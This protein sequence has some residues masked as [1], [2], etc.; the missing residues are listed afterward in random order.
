M[1]D[2]SKNVVIFSFVIYLVVLTNEQPNNTSSN[3]SKS[4]EICDKCDCTI[5]PN[6]FLLN[7]ANRDLHNIFT[8]WPEHQNRTIR[9]TFSNNVISTLEKFPN[10]NTSVMVSLD[11]CSI[12]YLSAGLFENMKNIKYIDLSYNL[13][14]IEEL[15]S[16]KFK[17]PYVKDEFEP[18]EVSHLN[19]AYNLIH[20]LP[21]SLFEHMPRL[22]TLNLEGN[23]IKILD[24][25]TK[26]ALVSIG[27]LKH[28][29]LANNGLQ[30]L[31]GD[32]LKSMTKLLK[33]NLSKNRM[34]FVPNELA[35]LNALEVLILDSNPIFELTDGLFNGLHNL[36]ELSLN[37]LSNVYE[38]HSNTF[39][40]LK[41][42]VKLHLS[43]NP[44]L[45]VFEPDAFGMEDNMSLREVYLNNNNLI[46]IPSVLLDWPSLHIFEFNNNPLMCSCNLYNITKML[47]RQI[48]RLKAGPFCIGEEELSYQ[49][50][51]L[52]DRVCKENYLPGLS[53][54]T[55]TRAKFSMI[56][57]TLVTISL[58]ALVGVFIV[59]VLIFMK[60]RKYGLLRNSQLSFSTTVLYNPLHGQP[61]L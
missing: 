25:Q 23:G 47:R 33:I 60:Q 59:I 6:L 12:K 37:N 27:S 43:N 53:F 20:S 35:N 38:V 57:I 26:A 44:D 13:I 31:P 24:E 46:D 48:T 42:L 21:K 11:H 40:P 39:R 14:T 50:F 30:Q 36:V 16:E 15:S 28:L 3:F 49:V 19:L 8:I 18:I 17:G 1:E 29:N 45:D 4:V 2:N 32:M 61:I 58:V 9:A 7:C 51:S 52:D 41:K 5:Y 22:T 54:R 34:T 10:T 56:R 55:M